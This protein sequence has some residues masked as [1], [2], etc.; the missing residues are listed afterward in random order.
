MSSAERR[1]VHI[2]WHCINAGYNLYLAIL[3]FTDDF[4]SS[5]K[6]VDFDTYSAFE[7][8]ILSAKNQAGSVAK[9]F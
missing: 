1:K 3:F 9:P 7:P 5:A 4:I 8:H 2:F 6:R